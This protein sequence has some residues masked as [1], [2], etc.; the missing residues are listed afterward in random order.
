MPEDPAHRQGRL[1]V[2]ILGYLAVALLTLVFGACA[3]AGFL[4]EDEGNG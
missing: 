2:E 4:K 1:T 3:L